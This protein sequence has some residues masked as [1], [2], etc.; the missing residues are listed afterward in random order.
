MQPKEDSVPKM[1]GDTTELYCYASAI[2][3]LNDDANISLLDLSRLS[4]SEVDC[5]FE[6]IKYWLIYGRDIN[7][8]H[9]LKKLSAECRWPRQF[10]RANHETK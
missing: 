7:F 8:I 3:Q 1:L 4:Y 2:R 5:L 6:E 10:S 9:D